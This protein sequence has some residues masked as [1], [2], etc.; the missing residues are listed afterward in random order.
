[1]NTDLLELLHDLSEYMD[2]RADASADPGED[3]RPNAEMQL[4]VRI[5]DAIETLA[6]MLIRF[7]D[8]P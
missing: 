7:V 8:T 6:N 4:H 1:M 2:Q 3:F 5:V